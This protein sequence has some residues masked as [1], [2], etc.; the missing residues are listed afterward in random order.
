MGNRQVVRTRFLKK[1]ERH[2]DMLPELTRKTSLY[3][4]LF[5]TDADLAEEVRKKGCPYCGGPLHQGNY[6]RKPRGGPA[7]LPDE[8]Q[9]RHSLTICIGYCQTGYRASKTVPRRQSTDIS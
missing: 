1:N 4:L 3:N 5:L 2:G 6:P 8:L 7:D 9:I